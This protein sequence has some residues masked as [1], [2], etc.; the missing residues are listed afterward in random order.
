MS[1]LITSTISSEDQFNNNNNNT[2]FYFFKL[3]YLRNIVN[4]KQYFINTMAD[5]VRL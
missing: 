5:G 4:A 2:T 3:I 1:T